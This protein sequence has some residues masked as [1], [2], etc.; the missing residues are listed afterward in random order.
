M[1]TGRAKPAGGVLP[2]LRRVKRVLVLGRQG[3]GKGT[4]AEALARWLGLA[5]LS[6][7]YLLRRVC[8][9]GTELGLAA[10][11]YLEQGELFS[12]RLVLEALAEVLQGPAGDGFVMDGFPQTLIQAEKL[13][14]LVKPA[15]I[16]VAIV[17]EA[18][19]GVVIERLLR[20]R[21]CMSCGKDYR[22]GSYCPGSVCERCGGEIGMR[23]QDT[24]RAIEQRLKAAE[25]SMPPLLKWL[26]GHT[27]SGSRS[28]PHW[29]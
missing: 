10:S 16:D 21:V 3:A 28:G 13:E 9:G 8:A 12:H 4:Q 6:A 1:S 5:H 22:Y 19:L 25:E 11:A 24:P 18:P 2:P 23:E 15:R 17:L 14:E 26:E 7:G 20:R 29:R 27:R